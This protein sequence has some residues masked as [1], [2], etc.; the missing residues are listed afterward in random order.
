MDPN[1]IKAMAGAAGTGEDKKLYVD[2]V[3]G[4]TSWVGEADGGGNAAQTITTGLNI[5]SGGFFFIKN[6]TDSGTSFATYDNERGTHY[7]K[8]NSSAG[9][10]NTETQ[11][12]TAI[13]GTGF[14]TGTSN[15]TGGSAGDMMSA[16][17]FLK[18]PG[19]LDVV[20]YDGN[21]TNQQIAHGL[22]G[23]VGMMWV[24]RTD[25]SGEWY[26]Y[27]NE[28]GAGF[29]WNFENTG[30]GTSSTV[31]NNTTP[32]QTHFSVGSHNGT[33]ANGGEYIAYI[34]CNNAG[35]FG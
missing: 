2:E 21:G 31:W 5:S 19:F 3:F 4:V 12:V 14:T 25:S 11:F 34:F 1:S 10:E 35:A 23:N 8:L 9:S 13:S 33:N 17:T 6:R 29:Y 26:I 18:A 32:T 15:S 7:L 24:K 22:D 20:K 16:Y 30:L 28:A 27:H